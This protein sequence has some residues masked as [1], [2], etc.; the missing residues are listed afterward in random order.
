[1]KVTPKMEEIHKR[2][3][4][5]LEY[6]AVNGPILIKPKLGPDVVFSLN[7]AQRILHNAIEKQRAEKGYVRALV[8][9]GRQQGVSTYVNARFYHKTRNGNMNT[10]ILSHEIKTTQKLFKM[11]NKFH[12]GLQ[13]FLRPEASTQNRNELVFKGINSEYFIGTAGN[14]D[15]GRGGTVQLFHGSEVAFWENTDGIKTGVM[16]SVPEGGKDTEVILE[17]TANGMQ[18]MFYE[19][20]MAAQE[21][22]GDYI[23]VFIP[24]FVT[25]EYRREAPKDFR[26]T[27]EEAELKEQ[28]GLDND[29][30]YWRRIKIENGSLRQFKQEYPCNVMEAFQT[31]GSGL[32]APELIMRARHNKTK[33]PHAP[34]VFG[35]D[36]AR[37]GGDKTV[38]VFRRGREVPVMMEWDTMDSMRLA[39]IVA[40]LIDKYSP[41]KVFIDVGYGH[42]TID[43]LKELGYGRI[44]DGINFGWSADNADQYFNK[45]A[46]MWIEMRDWFNQEDV[47]V[48][49]DDNLHTD[50]AIMPDYKLTSN[51]KMQLVSKDK[52]REEWKRSPD[53]GD[54]L[55]LTFAQPI[56]RRVDSE[57][58]PRPVKRK[59]SGLTNHRVR[60]SKE[61]NILFGSRG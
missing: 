27:D 59:G 46:E 3:M 53:R 30:L 8:L 34:L 20:C 26:L 31:T 7:H 18:G 29:Q 9:K 52:I 33:D 55:A 51:G 36:P 6:F 49:D 17:S 19:M 28:Y 16:E 56:M 21:G 25:P 1:M 50:L 41:E 5:D 43:R 23:L 47:N 42:G 2:M 15:V 11:V 24:W 35:V 44:V 60:K 45:R 12:E 10:F 32:I 22:K 13:P 40:R 39:G 38:I 48:P 4:T 14:K 57:G 37:S 58:L 54:A 61:R